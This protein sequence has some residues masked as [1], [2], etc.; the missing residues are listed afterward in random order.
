M[1]PRYPVYVISKGRWESRQTARALEKIGVPYRIV[2]EPQERDRYAEVLDPAKILVL[3]F[4][5]LGM[6]SMPARN[7]VWEHAIK[8]GHDRHWILDDNIKGFYRYNRNLK[9]PVAD[10][11]IFAAAEDFTDR[12]L[13]V[14]MSGFNYH[15]FVTRKSGTIKP[16]T[17]N[18]R[19]YSCI[20]LTNHTN[21]RWRGR[22]QEDTDLSLRFL[23]TGFCTILFN[24][25]LADKTTT[26]TMKG[27]N[28][29]E[30]YRKGNT[31]AGR[32]EQARTVQ[33]IHPDVGRVVW[34]WN[35][36]QHYVDYRPFRGNRLLRRPDLAI[37]AGV[38][39][40]G[41]RLKLIA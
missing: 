35:R 28:T 39:D 30:L 8:E 15:M 11:T 17:L 27:G 24:A 1:N 13:N 7:W 19:V 6:G 34:R 41:M 16:F 37:P 20:L 18:T 9:V 38:D 25:Y 31:F 33:R 4:A 29:D 14:P 22:Y 21:L 3:P 40:Y 32:V 12:Y 2:V 23:K 5:N 10:G 26:L 36:W